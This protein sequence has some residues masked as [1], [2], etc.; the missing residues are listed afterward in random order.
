[1][2][3]ET[4]A[5]SWAYWMEDASSLVEPTGMAATALGLGGVTT[6]VSKRDTNTVGNRVRHRWTI[7]PHL[8]L[9]WVDTTLELRISW[10][11]WMVA[12]VGLL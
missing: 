2:S 1:M 5:E 11:D 6:G 9:I 3:K 10:S 8:R 4:V 12:Y 7:V